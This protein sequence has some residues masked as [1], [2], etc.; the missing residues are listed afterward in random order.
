ML[1]GLRTMAWTLEKDGGSISNFVLR[2]AEGGY[3]HLLT[4]KCLYCS[5]ANISLIFIISQSQIFL[6]LQ[7]ILFSPPPSRRA[8]GC[9]I[10]LLYPMALGE[11]QLGHGLL[12]MS[13]PPHLVFGSSF[14]LLLG[15]LAYLLYQYPVLVSTEV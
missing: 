4:F 14:C 5:V 6:P 13:N 9:R 1:S 3:H 12:L 10:K 2:F 15:R 8:F 11:G 7:R